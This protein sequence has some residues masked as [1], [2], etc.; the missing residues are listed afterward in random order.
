MAGFW[1]ADESRLGDVSRQPLSVFKQM[2]FV[3]LGPEVG[4]GA[5]ICNSD[6]VTSVVRL[7][8]RAAALRMKES[9]PTSVV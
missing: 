8:L 2:E 1:H 6:G 5:S 4:V 9:L 3:A 7:V